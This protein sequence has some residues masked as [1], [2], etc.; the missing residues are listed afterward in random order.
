MVLQKFL[1]RYNKCIAAGGD[2]FKG[3]L[4]F[5]CPINKSANTKKVLKPI[6][7]P[8]YMCVFVRFALVFCLMAYQ[9]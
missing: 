4:S 2:Y 6:V 9:H 3:D 1:E 5:M 7:C 8:S